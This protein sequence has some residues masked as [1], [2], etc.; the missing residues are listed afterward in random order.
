MVYLFISLGIIFVIALI[1]LLYLLTG[2]IAY[3]KSF[4]NKAI[5]AQNE[6]YKKIV[7]NPF[8]KLRNYEWVHDQKIQSLSIKNDKNETLTAEFINNNSQ[9]YLIYTHGFVGHIYEETN[10][11]AKLDS[12]IKF[13]YLFI[14]QR[15]HAGSKIA[16]CTMGLNESK[17]LLTWIDYINKL[18]PHYKIVLYGMSMG[19]F[20]VMMALG[21]N[22]KNVKCAICDCGFS[23]VYEQCKYVTSFK[24]K[25]LYKILFMPG[26]WLFFKLKFHLDIKKQNTKTSLTRTNIPVCL[27]HGTKDFSVPYSN[28]ELNYSYIKDHTGT[29]FESFKD[30]PHGLSSY[31]YF[32]QY[33][34]IISKFVKIN[35]G[36]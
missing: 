9:Y 23:S 13:N 5:K 33:F 21:N 27:I 30:V 12:E 1:F 36:D 10:V 19:A 16:N 24:H 20:T 25:V 17:D 8:L 32:N 29:I 14:H 34:E 22:P 11:I 6:E 31:Y 3:K 2:Y 7:D 28:S 18:N 35:V 15:G 4:T 26:L